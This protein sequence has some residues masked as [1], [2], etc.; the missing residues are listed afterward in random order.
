MNYL[1]FS[2]SYAALRSL[3]LAV[4]KSSFGKVGRPVLS[5]LPVGGKKLAR[6]LSTKVKCSPWGI[7]FSILSLSFIGM[8]YLSTSYV[9][10]PLMV[11]LIEREVK[12]LST[13]CIDLPGDTWKNVPYCIDNSP[14]ERPG[15]EADT[16]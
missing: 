6:S 7:W 2:A 16:V 4:K 13:D 5:S 3:A 14:V 8:V 1:E 12:G 10:Y 11:F 15:V 9:N